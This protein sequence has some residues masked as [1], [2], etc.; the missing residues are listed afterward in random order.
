MIFQTFLKYSHLLWPNSLVKIKEKATL[1]V[2]MLQSFF[3][4]IPEKCRTNINVER[5]LTT[6]HEF[7]EG[8]TSS[9]LNYELTDDIY[10]LEYMDHLDKHLSDAPRYLVKPDPFFTKEIKML[11]K[12]DRYLRQ[13]LFIQK[14]IR[15]LRYLYDTIINGY[16]N[17]V[18]LKG[19]QTRIMFMA[20]NVGHFCLALWVDEDENDVLK[21]ESKP[22]YLLFLVVL[23]EMEMK[24][25]VFRELKVSKYTKSKTLKDKKLPK[26]YFHIISTVC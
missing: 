9:R 1:I 11:Q 3:G 4:R 8:N 2:E 22:P 26:G 25:I 10:L 21:I 5:Q 15:F 23:V 24:K 20:E 6:L 16:I 7:I 13:L 17:H 18:K 19:L 14:K 12:T